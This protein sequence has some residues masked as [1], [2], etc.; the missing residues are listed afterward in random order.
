MLTVYD[1]LSK[2]GFPLLEKKRIAA[3]GN[4]RGFETQHDPP[5]KSSRAKF[6]LRHPHQPICGKELVAASLAALLLVYDENVRVKHNHPF[7]LHG[8]EHGNRSGIGLSTS[9]R[10]AVM[11]NLLK[12]GF[13]MHVHQVFS[14]VIH[15]RH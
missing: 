15:A 10:S 7:V 12:K 14:T 2:C 1:G 6:V 3:L 8:H 9:T 4:G 11:N 13:G 5:G